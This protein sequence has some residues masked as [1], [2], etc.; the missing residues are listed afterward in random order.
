M[1]RPLDWLGLVPILL[2]L[3]LLGEPGFFGSL[4]LRGVSLGEFEE[5]FG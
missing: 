5:L 1:V 4:A 3:S 2:G